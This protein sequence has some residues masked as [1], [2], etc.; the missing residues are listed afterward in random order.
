M[1]PVQHIFLFSLI[2]L[3]G[4]CS[5]VVFNESVP[6]DQHPLK[7]FPKEIRGIYVDSEND[8]LEISSN[9]YVYGE[10][11]SNTLLEGELG[12]ELIIKKFEEFYFLNFK[13]ENGFWEMI[14][15]RKTNNGLILMCVDI[16]NK[17][18][19]KNINKHLKKGKAKM[20]RK[21]GKYLINPETKELIKILNDTSVCKESHLIKLK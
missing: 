9:R 19:I 20:L 15:A 13:N 3:L 21:E 6:K 2:V 8:T 1:K 10:L 5:N 4:S 14:A 12:E 16:E 11:K 18:E 17:N 7:E